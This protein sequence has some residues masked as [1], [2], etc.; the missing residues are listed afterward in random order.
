MNIS[1]LAKQ[2]A[3][4]DD[5]SVIATIQSLLFVMKRFGKSLN[6]PSVLTVLEQSY[7]DMVALYRVL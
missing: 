4:T 3:Q 1:K 7:P 6:T 2:L 5:R